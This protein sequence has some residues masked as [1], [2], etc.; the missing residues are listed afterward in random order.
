MIIPIEELDAETL[1]NIVESVVLREGTDYGEEELS[2]ATKVEQL[3]TQLRNGEA[4]LQYSE[5]HESV[6]IVPKA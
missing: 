4:V 5:L 1:Q 6:D 2:F 3:L